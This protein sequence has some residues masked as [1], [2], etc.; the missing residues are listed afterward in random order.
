M[1]TAIDH[2]LIAAEPAL[3]VHCDVIEVVLALMFT[4]IDHTLV[5]ADYRAAGGL[6]TQPGVSGLAP[7][8]T[9][10]GSFSDQISTSQ[11]CQKSDQKKSRIL[12]DLEVNLTQFEANAATPVAVTH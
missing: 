3:T 2:T 7:N 1:F 10:S 5:V 12:S 8:G 6:G 11:S 9:K 4:A